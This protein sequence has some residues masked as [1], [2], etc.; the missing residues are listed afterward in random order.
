MI[1]H[2]I[3]THVVDVCMFVCTFGGG[4]GTT[5][6]FGV[7]AASLSTSSSRGCRGPHKRDPVKCHTHHWD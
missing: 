3:P 2:P 6:G 1:V 4:T 5:G 7:G